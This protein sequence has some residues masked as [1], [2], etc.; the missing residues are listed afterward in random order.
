MK[1][2]YNVRVCDNGAVFCQYQEKGG[3]KEVAF[4]GWPEFVAWL[5]EQVG[6]I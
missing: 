1:V 3:A 2:N 4:A 6:V 5:K